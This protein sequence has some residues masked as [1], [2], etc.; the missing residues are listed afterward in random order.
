MIPEYIKT[1]CIE[2]MESIGTKFESY[3]HF[4]AHEADEGVHIVAFT[5]VYSDDPNKL[6]NALKIKGVIHEHLCDDNQPEPTYR[7]WAGTIY[8]YIHY[9][10]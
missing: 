8:L 10:A 6:P 1:H 5:P 2:P 3:K 7:V 9:F 4:T